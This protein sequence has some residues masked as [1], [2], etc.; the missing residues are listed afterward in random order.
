MN[1]INRLIAL[2]FVFCFA[3]QSTLSIAATSMTVPNDANSNNIRDN[4]DQVI[5]GL[6]SQYSL[7]AP[8]KRS[9]EQIARSYSYVLIFAPTT[10][11]TAYQASIRDVAA[12]RCAEQRLPATSLDLVVER[13]ESASLD[14]VNSRNIYERY[15]SLLSE[16]SP[17]PATSTAC[18]DEYNSGS[19]TQ[20]NTGNSSVT[21]E[22]LPC[23]VL[24][25]FM[26]RGNAGQQV[27]QLQTFLVINGDMFVWPNGYYGPN[28]AAA[29]NSFQSKNGI[30]SGSGWTGPSTRAKIA[31]ITCNGDAA[32]ISRAR[33]GYM[34]ART[35]SVTIPK[36]TTVI[37]TTSN[38]VN[39]PTTET[40]FM[41]P[42]Y[43]NNSGSAIL[44][45]SSGN[46]DTRKSPINS[47]YFTVKADIVRDQLFMCSEKSAESKC[48]DTSNYVAIKTKYDPL[49]YDSIAGTDRWIFN[50]YYNSNVWGDS[51]AKI[52]FRNG[53]GSIPSVYTVNVLR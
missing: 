12:T 28:T 32:A 38:V 49:T 19:N 22:T 30:A 48:G 53:I 33:K 17:N 9:I 18:E 10:P 13:I 37:K 15:I 6:V 39:I 27:T 41:A 45:N 35:S 7:S 47:L 40:R 3:F 14:D 23:L 29:I 20:T 42:A 44:S 2:L 24:T 34:I 52:Y 1:K 16:D 5:A 4:V 26:E 21:N 31:E 25:Q 11:A 43:T 8:Q 51:G 50:V 36:T 46:F